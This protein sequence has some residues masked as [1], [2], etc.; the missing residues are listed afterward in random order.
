MS[1]I[2][3][4]GYKTCFFAKRA[5][6]K[7]KKL[8]PELVTGI[9]EAG[10]DTNPKEIQSTCIPKIKSGADIFVIAPEDSGKS[11]AI[12][13]STIQQLKSAFEEAPR[14][15]IIASTRDKVFELEEK[16]KLLG[17]HTNLR[18]FV[19]FD[20]GNIEYQKN[21]IY[22]GLDI[23]IGTPIRINELLSITG[24]PTTALK[25]LAVDDAETIFP[26]RHHPVVY[27]IL[28]RTK[29]LQCIV[30]ANKLHEKFD[31]FWERL[32]KNPIIIKQ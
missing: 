8:L 6:M 18:T 32:E 27:R 7:L 11:T 24:I 3:E 17:G 2:K 12:V 20:K 29:K 13:I 26:H 30:F 25:L 23:L 1:A 14:A 19:V 16:F 10:Y 9:V 21:M 4:S 28:D 15:I 5:I 31:D 22:E